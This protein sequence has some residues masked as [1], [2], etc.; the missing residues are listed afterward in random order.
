MVKYIF[1][2]IISFLLIGCSK[3]D[4]IE[5]RVNYH[6]LSQGQTI[7]VYSGDQVIPRGNDAVIDFVHNSVTNTK[8][9]TLVSGSADLFRD[10]SQFE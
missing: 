6:G 3:S 2:V 10:S 9:V 1:L 5:E 8:T 7:T 4:I